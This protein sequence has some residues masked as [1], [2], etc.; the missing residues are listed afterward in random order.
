MSNILGFFFRV[1]THSLTLNALHSLQSMSG[2]RTNIFRPNLYTV[3]VNSSKKKTKLKCTFS[4]LVL[5][6]KNILYQND[7]KGFLKL[8]NPRKVTPGEEP[9][10]GQT[11][12]D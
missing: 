5:L 4:A 8:P 6:E 10:T 11:S 12:L 7:S 9:V 3:F 1:G 2:Q